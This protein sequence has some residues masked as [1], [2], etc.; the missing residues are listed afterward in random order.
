[1]KNLI[2]A[3]ASILALTANAETVP[4]DP[5]AFT[6]FGAQVIRTELGPDTPVKVKSP[7]TLQIDE[8]QVNLDRV[9]SFCRMNAADCSAALAE[10][11]KRVHAILTERNA[12]VDSKSVMLAIRSSAYL[13][14]AQ[15]VLGKEAPALQVRPLTDGLVAVAMLDTP[16]AARPLSSKDA[17]RLKLSGD[18]LFTLAAQNLRATLEPLSSKAKPA[19]SGQVG[20]LQ[21]GYYESGRVALLADWAE[22]A[23]AQNGILLISVP[24]PDVILY[25]SESTP[26][27]VDALRSLAKTVAAKSQAPL[28]A[29]VM[30][31]SADG[32][33]N[34]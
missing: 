24:S 33:V 11:S 7:L 28:S 32:W 26:I 20:T 3:F 21:G 23:A 9:Y 22:L 13:K 10:Y 34:Q 5:A 30:R 12:P 2:C 16:N 31:W 18:Q 8:L 27:A 17:E 1:M 14:N 29:A 25:I 19:G 15:A 6:E 4:T